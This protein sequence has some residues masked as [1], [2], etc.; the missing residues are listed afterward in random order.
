MKKRTKEEMA[1]YQ[2]ER[3]ARANGKPDVTPVTPVVTPILNDT[4]VRLAY[5][6]KEVADLAGR[7]SEVERQLSPEE[8]SR[9][10]AMKPGGR[11]NA[12]YGA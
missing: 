2:R 1:A 5:L 10:E 8:V 3:R 7:V 11:P 6:E 4:I 9:R 12:L